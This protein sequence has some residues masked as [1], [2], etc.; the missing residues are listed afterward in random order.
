MTPNYKLIYSDLITKKCPERIGEFQSILSKDKLSF[1]DIIN[2]NEKIFQTKKAEQEDNQKYRSYSKSDI[3]RI[4]D[5]QKKHR[6]NNLQL[7]HHF[8]LSRNTVTKWR[9][10]FVV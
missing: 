7:A 1:L 2:L 4:L 8:R 3:L 6:L 5:Y 10:L 9:K